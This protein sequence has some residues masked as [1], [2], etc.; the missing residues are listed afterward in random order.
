MNVRNCRRCGRIFTYV[1]GAPMCPTCREL[2]EERFQKVKEY[3]QTNK[4]TTIRAVAEACEV[5][6]A[7]IR[8]WVREERLVFAEGSGVGV[9]C[10]NC[11]TVIRTGRYCDRCKAEMVRTF[12]AAGRQRMQQQVERKDTKESPRMRFLDER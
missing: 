1:A 2:M 6:E 5:D 12:S 10:E 4:D 7:Q 3:I 8:Q 11:G 9:E